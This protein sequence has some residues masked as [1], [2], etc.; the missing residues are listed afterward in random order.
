ML[1][2]GIDHAV[3]DAGRLLAQGDGVGGSLWQRMHRQE[4]RL[5]W[6]SRIDNEINPWYFQRA[7]GCYKTEKWCV[8]WYGL[9]DYDDIKKCIDRALA[10]PPTLKAHTLGTTP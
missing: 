4:D 6:R 3:E 5:F 9:T 7:D 10:M 8:F 2:R 1:E